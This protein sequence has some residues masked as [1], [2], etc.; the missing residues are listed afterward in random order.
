M[1]YATHNIRL[2]AAEIGVLWTNYLANSMAHC[3]LLHFS[4]TTE[5]LQIKDV[6]DS[7]LAMAARNC[8][9][10]RNLFEKDSILAPTLFGGQ[11]VNVEAP[12]L[13][14]DTFYL[15]YIKQMASAGISVYG[16]AQS[17]SAREDVHGMFAECVSESCA[18][19]RETTRALL[20]K[21]IYVRPPYIPVPHANE[22]VH[23]QSFFNGLFGDQRPINAIEI[24]HLYFNTLTNAIGHVLMMGFSQSAKN[25]NIV[26]FLVHGRDLAMKHRNTLNKTLEDDHLEAPMTW[27]H[28]VS[29]STVAPFSEKLMVFHTVSLI[30]EGIG[31]YGI[32][33]A[34]SQRRD[35]AG[36]YAGL[37]AE[38]TPFAQEGAALMVENGWLEKPPSAVERDSLLHLQ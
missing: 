19:L 22:L 32:A 11:D 24:T 5:D 14:A 10:V 23:K 20:E 2:T 33:A 27:D 1:E 16:V 12:P 13:F 7:A 18:L 25:P 31:N 26:K 34:N 37:V 35:L 4:N 15:Q 6:V 28:F 8:E 38:I 36:L 9:R 17:V 30:V 21:G 3:V 29:A